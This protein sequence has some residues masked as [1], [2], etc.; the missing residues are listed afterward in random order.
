MSVDNVP[1]TSIYVDSTDSSVHQDNIV[2]VFQNCQ[3]GSVKLQNLRANRDREVTTEVEVCLYPAKVFSSMVAG[4]PNLQE[5]NQRDR[6]LTVELLPESVTPK[7]NVFIFMEKW[8][9]L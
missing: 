4:E 8:D 9:E 2:R 3:N 6:D 7:T 1:L 5:E